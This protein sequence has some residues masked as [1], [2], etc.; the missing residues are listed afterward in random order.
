MEAR[1]RPL[2]ERARPARKYRE[3]AAARTLGVGACLR[4]GM[5]AGLLA[6]V[7]AGLFQLATGERSVEQAIR[8]E[9][10]ASLASGGHPTEMFSRGVQ[11][12]GMV[13]ATGLYGVALGGALAIAFLVMS[14]RMRGSAWERSLKIALAG[15][16]AFW[17]VPFL[18]YPANPPGIGDP[19]TIGIRT[20]AYLTIAAVSVTACLI[21][22]AAAR[23]LAARGVEPHRRQLI[24]GAAY[25]FVLAAAFILLPPA[26]DPAGFPAG[27]LWDFRLA[28]VGGQAILWML[29]GAGLGLLMLR[30]ERRAAGQESPP[31]TE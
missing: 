9:H 2:D 10:L 16:G 1:G 7:A 15:F 8:L 30:A 17:L 12:F 22:V 26:L 14:R 31:V 28:S 18:K 6:G 4:R 13:L 27:L 24:V 29:A 20:A 21:G 11:R 19:S 23:Q 3:A 5:G 25:V